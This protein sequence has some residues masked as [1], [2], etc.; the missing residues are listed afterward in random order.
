MG[1]KSEL[2]AIE[3]GAFEGHIIHCNGGTLRLFFIKDIREKAEDNVLRNVHNEPTGQG[4]P[5][6]F[7]AL[8]IL[9]MGQTLMNVKKDQ[10]CLGSE[11]SGEEMDEKL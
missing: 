5:K 3:Y 1:I 2:E 10:H 8:L 9:V 6:G 7:P 4:L 11:S